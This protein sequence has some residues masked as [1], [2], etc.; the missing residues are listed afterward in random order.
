MNPQCWPVA[1]VL[2][3]LVGTVALCS[4]KLIVSPSLIFYREKLC[5]LCLKPHLPARLILWSAVFT[6]SGLAVS[7]TGLQELLTVG[8]IKGEWP[9]CGSVAPGQKKSTLAVSVPVKGA[10]RAR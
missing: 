2:L 4:R 5:S 10:L 6:S 8:P 1:M 7:V 3:L 9:A